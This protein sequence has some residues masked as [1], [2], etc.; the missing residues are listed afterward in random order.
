MS[1]EIKDAI[2]GATRFA[3]YRAAYVATDDATYRA[4]SFATWVATSTVYDATHGVTSRAA[5]QAIDD[6]VENIK[7][8]KLS[9]GE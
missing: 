1:Y 3:T 2:S 4:A 5:H 6:I 7:S 9:R 8:S